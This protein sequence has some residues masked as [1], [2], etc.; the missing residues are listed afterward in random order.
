MCAVAIA[1]LEKV[2]TDEVVVALEAKGE[3]A[4]AEVAFVQ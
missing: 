3:G 1:A 4:R 2:R